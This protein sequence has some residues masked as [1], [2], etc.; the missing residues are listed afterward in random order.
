MKKIYPPAG[1]PAAL[2][3]FWTPTSVV[4]YT[5]SAPGDECMWAVFGSHSEPGVAYAVGA[6]YAEFTEATGA[7]W[8]ARGQVLCVPNREIEV[9][10]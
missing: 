9:P 7:Q 10:E 3:P 4:K 2:Y 6:K 8:F 1:F 5:Q